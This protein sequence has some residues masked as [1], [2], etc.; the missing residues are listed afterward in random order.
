[1]KLPHRYPFRWLDPPVSSDETVAGGQGHDEPVRY[2]VLLSASAHSP[3][4]QVL[5]PF[6]ALEIVAQAAAGS[7][8]DAKGSSD[9]GSGEDVTPSQPGMLAAIS[10]ATFDPQLALQPLQAGDELEVQ[11]ERTASLGQLLKVH[12][13]LTRRN[14]RVLEADL[15]LTTPT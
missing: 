7:A 2:R 8:G 13:S 3:R 9:G 11:I 15:I 1:M 4:E 6:V 12:G 10:N 14:L 5:S